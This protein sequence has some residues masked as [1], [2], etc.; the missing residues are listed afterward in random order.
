MKWSENLI[1]GA[2]AR[3]LFNRRG[4]VVVPNCGWTG[5]ECDL[6]VVM[7]DLR[8]VDVEI[9]ISV[10]DL[11]ADADKFKWYHSWDWRQDGLWDRKTWRERR[12]R[13]DWPNKVWKHYYAFPADLWKPG[14]MD[15]LP[16]NSGVLLL[17][18]RRDGSIRVKC[19]RRAKPCRDAEKITAADAVDI[20]RLASLRMWDMVEKLEAEK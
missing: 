4:L 17:S 3:Q 18:K 13:R 12:R 5:S 14:L 15:G 16:K 19:V 11:K 7:P 2:L 20:A 9:K 1:A 6:L 10:A 8:I